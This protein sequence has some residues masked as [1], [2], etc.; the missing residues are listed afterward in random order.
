MED[1]EASEIERLEDDT[2]SR[3]ERFTDGSWRY[4]VEREKE[5]LRTRVVWRKL[6]G[7][8]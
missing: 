5:H 6:F 7:M 3:L 1:R 4:S 2:H 8:H